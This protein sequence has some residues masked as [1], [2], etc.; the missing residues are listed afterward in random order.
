MG[1]ADDKRSVFTT[2][3]SY[4]SLMEQGDAPKQTD[5]YKSINNNNSIIPF[6][7]DVLKT[8][9]GTVAVKAAIGGMFTGLVTKLEPKLKTALKKQFIQSNASEPLPATFKSDGVT[10][11]VKSL[12]ANNKLK[13]N[14]SSAN[15]NL[16]YGNP[17]DSFDGTA[18]DAI[19]NSGN[20]E[21]HNNMS[22]KYVEGTDSLQIKPNI[23]SSNPTIGEYFDDYIDNTELL[24]EKEITS[25]VMDNIYGT[26]A[27]SQEKTVEQ[28]YQELQL[29]KMLQQTLN[30]EENSFEISPEDYEAM[31][32]KA[33]ELAKG[34]V[35]YDMGCGL[36]PAQLSFDD[37]SK[38]ISNVSG[39][40]DPYYVGDQMEATIDQSSGTPETTTENK[41]TM[42]D[43]FFQ[44]II[45]AFTL[46]ITEAVTTAPQVATLFAMMTL[47]QNPDD[48]VSDNQQETLKKFQIC[49]KCMTKEIM[50]LVAAFIFA[51]AISY[52]IKLL[53]PV[54]KKVIKEKINQFVGLLKSLTGANK[55]T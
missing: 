12:D 47:L 1:L 14:P 49:I 16:I 51:L 37:F 34:V 30:E 28:I 29:Q 18:Y 48:A 10:T 8:V 5:S 21:T 9:A 40:T 38:L 24:N 44:K 45:E 23:G 17:S 7:L 54:I 43:G 36:M 53:K 33:R 19:Q 32:A 15:G 39:S 41:E 25:S 46:K 6:L 13:V 11:S 22:I 27:N 20:Y 35:N 42:K 3:G 2:I 50:A 31:L 26:L 52:L 55:F 4:N